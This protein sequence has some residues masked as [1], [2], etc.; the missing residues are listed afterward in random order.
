M[1]L[2]CCLCVLGSGAVVVLPGEF[3]G[4][5]P[6]VT[7]G[8]GSGA[9]VLFFSWFFR[10][11]SVP[12]WVTGISGLLYSHVLLLTYCTS[13]MIQVIIINLLIKKKLDFSS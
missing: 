11:L 4:T 2:S 3:L 10:V 8:Y 12:V 13:C 1:K 9:A 7:L 5:A 6:A